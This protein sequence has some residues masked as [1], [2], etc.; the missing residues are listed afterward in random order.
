MLKMR[1]TSRKHDQL[2]EALTPTGNDYVDD[3][4]FFSII[5][6]G[7]CAS[8]SFHSAYQ[9]SLSSGGSDSGGGSSGG[10]GGGGG[11]SGAF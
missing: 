4:S 9:S 7:P 2:I 3:G 5:Y 8:S 11:G 10:T 6:I 1:F